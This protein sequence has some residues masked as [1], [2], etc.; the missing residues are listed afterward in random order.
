MNGLVLATFSWKRESARPRAREICADNAT[1]DVLVFLDDHVI[2]N[3]NIFRAKLDKDIVFFPS[4][5]KDKTYYDYEVELSVLTNMDAT[6]RTEPRHN[7]IYR[8]LSAPAGQF[9]VKRSAWEKMGGYGGIF[10]GYSG[11]EVYFGMRAAMF[12]L[13]C[14]MAPMNPCYHYVPHSAQAWKNRDES[15]FARFEK[16][17]QTLKD[18]KAERTLEEAFEQLAGLNQGLVCI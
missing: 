9:M 12:N 3:P 2:V 17:L 11:E 8:V 4:V 16:G 6:I 5:C 13:E 18:L 15:F 7:F 1:G 14:W 10:D